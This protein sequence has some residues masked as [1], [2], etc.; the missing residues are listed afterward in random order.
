MKTTYD[1]RYDIAYSRLQ[2]RTAEIETIKV[3]DELNI[4]ITP[5]GTV[6]GIEL[7]HANTQFNLATETNLIYVNEAQGSV[8]EVALA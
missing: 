2:E 5:D 6:Y 7:L 3:S 8:Q 1:P 4:D